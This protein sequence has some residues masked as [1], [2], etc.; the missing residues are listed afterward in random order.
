MYHHYLMEN[1][2]Y[3]EEAADLEVVQ[4][5]SYIASKISD[6]NRLSKSKKGKENFVKAVSKKKVSPEQVMMNSSQ[7][8]MYNF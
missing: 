2:H 8:G 4:A 6:M 1:L 3:P 7:K 5:T